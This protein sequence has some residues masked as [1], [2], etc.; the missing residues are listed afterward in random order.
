MQKMPPKNLQCF[1]P[2]T[3][4]LG[5]L[6]NIA[7]NKTSVDYEPPPGTWIVCSLSQWKP[8]V[9]S[10]YFHTQLHELKIPP[11]PTPG[12]HGAC[13]DGWMSPRLEMIPRIP[14]YLKEL[15]KRCESSQLEIQL[16]ESTTLNW[17]L[18]HFNSKTVL[19]H[20]GRIP[21]LNFIAG[22]T[23]RLCLVIGNLLFSQHGHLK[24]AIKSPA[25]PKPFCPHAKRVAC[26]GSC[27]GSRDGSVGRWR[28]WPLGVGNWMAICYP[29][30]P[31]LFPNQENDYNMALQKMI[32]SYMFILYCFPLRV[33]SF[34]WRSWCGPHLDLQLHFGRSGWKEAHRGGPQDPC[35][36]RLPV[37]NMQLLGQDHPSPPKK[38]WNN[39]LTLNGVF[40]IEPL[41]VA[42]LHSFI[43]KG[44]VV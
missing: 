29:S 3:I 40:Q 6:K 15:L 37:C 19:L 5:H 25:K 39:C 23:N 26:H 41:D 11:P 9:E 8:P 28:R 14:T 21:L 12:A 42:T 34:E 33:K 24:A 31:L 43:L 7:K 22:S 27:H 30:N 44:D 17:Y 18:D 4:F 32:V 35:N 10:S 2:S 1:Y 36:I 38:N 16:I 13:E 20:F